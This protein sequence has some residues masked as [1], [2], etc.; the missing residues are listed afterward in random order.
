MTSPTEAQGS[1]PT[2]LPTPWV[3]HLTCPACSASGA[4][5]VFDGVGTICDECGDATRVLIGG[6]TEDT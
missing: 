5:R 4:L 2:A 6:G 3:T 1:Q